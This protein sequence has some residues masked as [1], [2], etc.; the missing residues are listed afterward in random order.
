MILADTNALIWF[1]ED[2]AALGP[3]ARRIIDTALADNMLGVS[4][5]S[6]W[7]IA[8]LVA[9]RRLSTRSD[10]V[11][12]RRRVLAGGANEIP[13]TGAI[14]IAA[15]TLPD[16]HGDPADRIIVATALAHDATLLTADRQLLGWSGPLKRHDA[17]R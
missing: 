2:E 6:F 12:F 9:R 3:A 7:E 5:F 15:V 4:A 10:P 11:E 16:L 8:L 17:R 14:G 1:L 13:V